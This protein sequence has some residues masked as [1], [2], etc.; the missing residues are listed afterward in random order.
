MRR[1]V[2]RDDPGPDAPTRERLAADVAAFRDVLDAHLAHEETEALP[3]VQRHLSQAAWAESE[4]AAQAEFTF[5]D[6]AFTLPWTALEVPREEIREVFAEGG[7]FLRVL[8]ALT[9][10][11]FM[12][13]HRVAFRWAS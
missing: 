12:R 2:P 3:L 6:I 13:D 5:A 10:R 4:K 11:R 7:L 8:L 9:R 1:G